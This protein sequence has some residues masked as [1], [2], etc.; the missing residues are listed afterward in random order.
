M[1][2]YIALSQRMR[3][4]VSVHILLIVIGVRILFEISYLSLT[5]RLRKIIL[6]HIIFLT[7]RNN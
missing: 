7:I 1:A 6:T 2:E 3:E 4:L 5:Y